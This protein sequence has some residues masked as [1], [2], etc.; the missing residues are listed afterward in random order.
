MHNMRNIVHSDE[1]LRSY[2]RQL[3]QEQLMIGW[4]EV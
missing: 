3:E 4:E 2:A 1:A